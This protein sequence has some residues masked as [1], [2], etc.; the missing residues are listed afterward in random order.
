[1]FEADEEE[2]R[3]YKT[4]QKMYETCKKADKIMSEFWDSYDQ[5]NYFT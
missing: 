5:Q 2:I 4:M 3:K 1:M